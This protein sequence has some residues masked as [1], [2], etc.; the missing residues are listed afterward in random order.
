MTILVVGATGALGSLAAEAVSSAGRQVVAMVRDRLSPGAAR[1]QTLGV[2]LRVADL[3]DHGQIEA[4]VRGVETVIVTATATL[5]RR[6]GDSLEAV[7]GRGLQNL[8]SACIRA[9]VVHVVFVSFSRGID[10]DTPL[11]RFKRTAER[12]LE[13]SGLEYSILLPSYFPEKFMTPLVGFDIEGGRV[14]IF[15]DGKRP[16]RYVATADVARLAAQCAM[17][18]RGHGL[19]PMGGPQAV[20]QLEAVALAERLIGRS[21]ALSHVSLDEIEAAMR[22]VSD[23]LQQSYLGL[24]RGLAMGDMPS[25]AWANDFGLPPTSLETCLKRMW[26]LEREGSRDGQMMIAFP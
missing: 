20:S 14:R 10:A 24:Y 15:G 8:I 2:E 23:P 11:A 6:T 5:S 9:G 16:I 17:E 19:I 12:R 21:F 22:R 25:F 18:S 3:K 7:D 1:L 13:S 26:R 4:A